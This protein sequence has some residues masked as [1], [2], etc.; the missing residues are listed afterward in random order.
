MK[1][2][3]I[4]L[5]NFGKK[6]IHPI[7]HFYQNNEIKITAVCDICE[8]EVKSVADQLSTAG[9]TNYKD[10]IDKAPID[11]VYIAA[12]P[13]LHKEI[14]TYALQAGKHV[15]C[16]K[17]LAHNL[18]DASKLVEVASSLSLINAM[19]FGQDYSPVFSSFRKHVQEGYLGN[20]EGI[21]LKMHYPSWPPT[22][23]QTEWIMTREQ[24][25]FLLEQGIHLIH[26]VR[27]LFGEISVVSSEITYGNEG[28][29]CETDV[30]AEM[31]I[32]GGIP[33]TLLGK[34]PSDGEEIVSLT[35]RGSEGTLMIENWRT[36][37]SAKKGN[38]LLEQ[39]VDMPETWI[40][41]EVL[42]AIHGEEANLTNFQD[43][44]EAL[45]VI[46]SIRI[47]IVDKKSI[48]KG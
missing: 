42:K 22:W 48:T 29:G 11:F 43:G 27:K 3:I 40:I 46:D 39:E 45:K 2:A 8:D 14:A 4:G 23:Q 36:L 41:D 5:G 37:K 33:F 6:I 25:G 21:E 10:C 26:F 20:L 15:L 16:E 47:G 18:E 19:H 30:N 12:P 7:G 32:A 28:M 34:W 9:Y 38:E 24:G 17:P 13:A 44:F 35:A 1:M 31:D